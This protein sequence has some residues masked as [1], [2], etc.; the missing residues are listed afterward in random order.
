MFQVSKKKHF[1]KYEFLM[2]VSIV[3]MMDYSFVP[4]HMCGCWWKSLV[5]KCCYHKGSMI[6][7]LLGH[8]ILLWHTCHKNVSMGTT[9]WSS[10]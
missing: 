2:K 6:L 5:H 7:L 1:F 4:C 3:N 8:I 10:K 9:H